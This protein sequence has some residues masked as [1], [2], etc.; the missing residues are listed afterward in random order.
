MPYVKKAERGI[1]TWTQ[2]QRD[3]W[4][5]YCAFLDA[6]GTGVEFSIYPP[7]AAAKKE[8]T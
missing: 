1:A 5:V 6:F 4:G 8:E 3:R 2:E 7:I